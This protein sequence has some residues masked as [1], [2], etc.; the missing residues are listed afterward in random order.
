MDSQ[1]NRAENSD[2]APHYHA[3]IQNV[4]GFSVRRLDYALASD[5]ESPKF[6][7]SLQKSLVTDTVRGVAAPIRVPP[8]D[9]AATRAAKGMSRPAANVP[10][11]VYGFV[12]DMANAGWI[13]F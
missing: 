9:A 4:P 11:F 12:G 5:N 7:A 13:T 8:K 1:F 10:G 2:S 3:D 6:T